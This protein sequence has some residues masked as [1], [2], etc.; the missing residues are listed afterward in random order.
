MANEE[1]YYSALHWAKKAEASAKQAAENAQS[2]G[3][4]L[5]L[6]Y[7]G[8]MVNG[9]LEFKHAPSGIEV[10]YTLVEGV[11][12]EMDL[13]YSSTSSLSSSTQMY[14]KNGSD[15]IR[16]VSAL[17]REASTNA[18]VADMDAV[19]RFNS[20][21]GYRWLFKAAYKVTPSG[22]KVFLLYPV[23]YK[24]A[25]SIVKTSGD[26]TIAGV[27]TFSNHPVLSSSTASMVA[28]INANKQLVSD[29]NVSTTEIAQLN[30]VTSN[31]QTQLNGKA[32][33]SVSN[34]NATGKQNIVTWGMPDYSA[35][36]AINN[37]TDFTCPKDGLVI[38]YGASSKQYRS[39][40]KVNGVDFILSTY[41]SEVAT[42]TNFVF[43]VEKGSVLH[44]DFTY[45]V[46]ATGI[47]FY[48]YKGA[49]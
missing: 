7:D 37:K 17:H 22:A 8:S 43:P 30:G 9:A 2:G 11:E 42:P 40:V 12:Y 19:M 3:A 46:A 29:A 27:K 41:W 5:Q 38:A 25:N 15:T 36:I 4:L 6:G 20:S 16:F 34:L 24:D 18:T 45:A 21:T 48:P 47:N 49:N 33:T 1:V 44:F 32:N 14:V 26:Q 39:W 13:A 31:I 10:P 35:G 23:A 28:I